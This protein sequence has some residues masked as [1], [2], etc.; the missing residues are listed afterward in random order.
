MPASCDDG[1]ISPPRS[2]DDGVVCVRDVLSGADLA[3]LAEAVEE[4]L[5]SP[6]PWA[7]DYTP[8][9]DTGRFFGDYV[10]WERFEGYRRLALDGPL[11]RLAADCSARHRASSTNTR[12]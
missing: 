11:P 8:K 12:W 1:R 5:A 3:L 4:N 10:N 9:G 2:S 7:N 6:G